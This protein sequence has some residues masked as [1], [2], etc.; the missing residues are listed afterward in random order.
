MAEPLLRLD[1]VTVALDGRDVVR[2]VSF[3]VGAGE[4]VAIVGPNGSGKTVLLKAILGILPHRGTIRWSRP[5]AI[6]YVPQRIDADRSVPL[7]IRNLLEAKA[8]IT[9]RGRADIDE[10]VDSVG[11]SAATLTTHLGS[12]SGGQFQRALIAFAIL[13]KPDIVL[14]DEPTASIDE[15]GE[16]DVYDL[17]DRLRGG[18][19]MAIIVISHD[20]PWVSHF[21]TRVVALERI[22]R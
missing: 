2:D 10:V 19:E 13:G 17:L 22:I 8:R 9:G 14:F 5:A 12:L 16:E 3:D 20:L 4:A 7:N 18:G 6:G 11:L 21:A 1:S 15:E